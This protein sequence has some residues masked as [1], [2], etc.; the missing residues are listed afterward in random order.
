MSVKQTNQQI[1]SNLPIFQSTKQKERF[2]FVVGALVSKLIS[3]QK[4]A[5]IMEIEVE[6]FLQLL[7]VVGIDF[8]YLSDDDVALERSW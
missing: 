6:I 7:E 2:L 5:E 1:A 3:L 4:A 8:S